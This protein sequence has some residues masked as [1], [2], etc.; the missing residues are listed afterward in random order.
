MHGYLHSMQLT[1]SGIVV[2]ASGEVGSVV[3]SIGD[4]HRKLQP[5]LFDWLAHDV[6]VR[7]LVAVLTGLGA[8]LTVIGG[9]RNP[10]K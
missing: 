7:L 2:A 9:L 1:G 6:R 4:Q 8:I 3:M 5:T 10:T